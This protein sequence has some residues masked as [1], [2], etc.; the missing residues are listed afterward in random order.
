M[1]PPAGRP[2]HPRPAHPRPAT[3]L[4]AV[5][6]LVGAAAHVHALVAH[7]HDPVLAAAMA[8]MT[9]ACLGCAAEAWFA[10]SARGMRMLLVMSAAMALAHLGLVVDPLGAGMGGHAE[11]LGRSPSPGAG[12]A[13]ATSGGDLTMAAIIAIELVVAFSCAVV[14]GRMRRPGPGAPHAGA[15]R[16]RCPRR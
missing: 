6:A 10:P 5:L 12:D 16:R 13:E 4:V 15:T 14:L 2:A 3:R 9:L 7:A 11:H 8:V 1:Q